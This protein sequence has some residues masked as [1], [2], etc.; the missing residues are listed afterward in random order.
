[1]LTNNDKMKIFYMTAIL[2]VLAI[3]VGGVVYLESHKTEVDRGFITEV[4]GICLLILGQIINMF[5]NS[6]DNHETAKKIEATI[7]EIT[8]E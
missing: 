7:Q 3:W 6:A 8:K 5:K 1:M 4:S 2:G